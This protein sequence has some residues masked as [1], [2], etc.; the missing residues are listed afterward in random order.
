M[1]IPR[2]SLWGYCEDHRRFC[3]W[4]RWR[5][6]WCSVLGRLGLPAS[7]HPPSWVVTARANWLILNMPRGLNL[8]YFKGDWSWEWGGAQGNECSVSAPSKGLNPFKFRLK[9]HDLRD[10]TSILGLIKR[11]PRFFWKCKLFIRCHETSVY[12]RIISFRN[13]FYLTCKLAQAHRLGLWSD[14]QEF[15]NSA[16]EIIRI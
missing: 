16:S 12:Y 10:S 14:C 1:I 8:S 2:P 3:L 7:Q 4:T 6:T 11:Q 5:T 13:I 9:I 15:L